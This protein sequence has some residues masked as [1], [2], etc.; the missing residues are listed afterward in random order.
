MLFPLIARDS[1][2]PAALILAKVYDH[3]VIRG[4]FYERPG[5]SVPLGRLQSVEQ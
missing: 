1:M 5:G 2:T 4:F 3:K